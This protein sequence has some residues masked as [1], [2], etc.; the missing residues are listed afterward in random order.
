[1]CTPY[2]NPSCWCL[3]RRKEGQRFMAM[4]A[5]AETT[6]ACK[7]CRLHRPRGRHRLQRLLPGWCEL[8]HVDLQ[9]M[10]DQ[11]LRQHS[12]NSPH[13][14]GRQTHDSQHIAAGS[15]VTPAG[16]APLSQLL[17]TGPSLR[18]QQRNV[19]Q[20]LQ[21]QRSTTADLTSILDADRHTVCSATA[22]HSTL[23]PA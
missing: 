12:P 11:R 4:P 18:Q 7:G 16:P 10:S 9:P 2:R 14:T 6:L 21:P 22:P 19:G 23:Q 1:V 3:S 15:A 13:W 5:A 8:V 20:Q 17:Q